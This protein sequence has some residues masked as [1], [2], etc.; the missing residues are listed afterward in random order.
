MLDIRFIFISLC[1]TACATTTPLTDLGDARRDRPI[2]VVTKGGASYRFN[3][4]AIGEG[5]AVIGFIRKGPYANDT[6]ETVLVPA[7]S[8]QSVSSIDT[9][10]ET[11][12][13]ITLTTLGAVGGILFIWTLARAFSLFA[14]FQS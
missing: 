6:W 9:T 10:M 13:V 2:Q 12:G 3:N 1:F 14:G 4:W 5:K 8:I 11:V 7:D